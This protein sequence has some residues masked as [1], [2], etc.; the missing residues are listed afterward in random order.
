MR[1][2]LD[3]KPLPEGLFLA[4]CIMTL[5]SIPLAFI[6]G[7]KLVAPF[8][9]WVIWILVA[10]GMCDAVNGVAGPAGESLG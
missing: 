4:Y 3:A 7:V 2:T 1:H 5:A 6:P 10:K 9:S 8:V